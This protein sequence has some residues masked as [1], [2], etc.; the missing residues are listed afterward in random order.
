MIGM[1]IVMNSESFRSIYEEQKDHAV[2]FRSIDQ[3][4]NFLG[5]RN[6]VETCDPRGGFFGARLENRTFEVAIF[7]ED[8]VIVIITLNKG[9]ETIQLMGEASYA[10]FLQEKDEE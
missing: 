10:Q 4:I 7:D 8:V 9:Q 2:H 6:N 1:G 3:A 5:H